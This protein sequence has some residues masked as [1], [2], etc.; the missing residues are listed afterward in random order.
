MLP[1]NGNRK[2]HTQA[3]NQ[4][5]KHSSLP[6]LGYA[7]PYN[8]NHSSCKQMHLVL[9]LVLFSVNFVNMMGK[10]LKTIA[11]VSRGLKRNTNVIIV[12]TPLRIV[13]CG[14]WSLET[15][16]SLCSSG[17]TRFLLQTDHIALESLRKTKRICLD[18]WLDGYWYY[19]EYEF[20][21]FSISRGH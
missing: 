14:T 12:S 6:C 7:R 13:S 20:D 18:V 16:P 5:D 19:K 8:Q 2:V 17:K 21:V 9:V 1:G 15:I 10:W 4:F 11:Y 3:C